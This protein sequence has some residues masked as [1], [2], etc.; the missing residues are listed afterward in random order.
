MKIEDRYY[1]PDDLYDAVMAN[2]NRTRKVQFV[3]VTHE[4]IP[5]IAPGLERLAAL[6]D[7]L[8][9]GRGCSWIYGPS[10]EELIGGDMALVLWITPEVSA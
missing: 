1:I 9:S 10:R 8:C 7:D 3:G 4:P 2:A 6:W 5:W